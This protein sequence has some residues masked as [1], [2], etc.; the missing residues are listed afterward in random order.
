VPL[1]SPDNSV[2]PATLATVNRLSN[3]SV[4]R[5]MTLNELSVAQGPIGAMLNGMPMMADATEVPTLGTTEMWEIVNLTADTHPIHL[6]LVQFQLLNRQKFHVNRYQKAFDTAN[7][8]LPSDTYVPVSPDAYLQGKPKPADANERG[9]KD[10]YRMNPGEVTRILVRWAPQDDSP[11]YAFDATAEPGYV[12]HCHILEHEENDMM[13][14]FHLVAP[15][16]PSALA[17]RPAPVFV[18]Q[19]VL[20]APQP[21][22]TAAGATM[23]F[24]LAAAG[25][26]RLDLYTVSGQRVRTVADGLFEAGE[27][28]VRWDGAAEDGRRLAPGVYFANLRANGSSHT[29]R[30]LVTQ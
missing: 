20:L 1:T 12:W 19:T 7:P 5:V 6:H 11:A 27:H 15:A 13:R 16:V 8:T 29:Q 10:T 25:P 28:T 24:S 18:G 4:K 17:S 9:W 14:P 30:I 26:V 3:P 23:R 21:N 22:P 2:V